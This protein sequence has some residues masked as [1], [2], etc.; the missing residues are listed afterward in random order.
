AGARPDGLGPAAQGAGRGRGEG[1]IDRAFCHSRWS[2][3]WKTLS[4]C[5]FT[6]VYD[7]QFY[8]YPEGHELEG[9]G[10]CMRWELRP[11]FSFYDRQVQGGEEEASDPIIAT[12]GMALPKHV[13]GLHRPTWV[14]PPGTEYREPPIYHE[15]LAQAAQIIQA[16]LPWDQYPEEKTG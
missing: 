14:P 9:K 15:Q 12:G 13:P 3:V 5:Q 7:D 6:N 4:D 8:Y 2:S 11:A 16:G 10:Q 1:F